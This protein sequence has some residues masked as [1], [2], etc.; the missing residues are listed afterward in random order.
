MADNR[1]SVVGSPHIF[2]TKRR[3]SSSGEQSEEKRQHHDDD[4]A[5][6]Y[7]L[8]DSHDVRLAIKDIL[9]DESIADILTK[10]IDKKLDVVN[11]E[12]EKM[13]I[14]D[15]DHETRIAQLEQRSD[16]Q[17]QDTRSKNIV[18]TGLDED[19]MNR[20]GAIKKLN[21]LLKTNLTT[22]DIN[23]VQKLRTN[24]DAHGRRQRK[25]RIVFKEDKIRDDIFKIKN[26]LKGHDLWITDD[27]TAHN[28]NLAYL[29]RQA[30]R[31]H[32]LKKTWVFGGKVFVIKN[33]DDR[34][35][36]INRKEDI[37]V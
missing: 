9:T 5:H 29:A 7:Q 12:I 30:F 2:S 20:E 25:M 37:P 3:L 18:L 19:Q 28:S 35:I 10:T 22:A 32:K 8:M 21:E 13:K 34:P 33:G 26:M 1:V 27:L 14:T 4:K 11:D 17:I 23:W 31:L 6:D 15:I 24:D 36:K 16:R